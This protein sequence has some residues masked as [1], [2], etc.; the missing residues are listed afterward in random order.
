[1]SAV[2]SFANGDFGFVLT[3]RATYS[4]DGVVRQ[5]GRKVTVVK[6][7]PFAIACR[8]DKAMGDA[9][10]SKIREGVLQFGIDAF[11]EIFERW[12][13]GARIDPA[14]RAATSGAKTVEVVMNGW[15]PKRG[16]F[17]FVFKTDEVDADGSAY[18]LITPD[19]IHLGVPLSVEPK[20]CDF[21]MPL[22]GEKPM[23]WAIRTGADMMEFFRRQLGVSHYDSEASSF[24]AV[25][26]GVDL[27][28]ITPDGAHTETLRTWPDRVGEKIT[29][30]A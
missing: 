8:G 9:F 20:A 28:I 19:N 6:P 1:M 13:D 14:L 4:T 5:I 21:E 16:A 12:L 26:G 2:I 10:R 7:L 18:R 22:P 15:S 17:H 25:G 29:H 24:Y 30:A 27:T 11:L 23:A 3:D